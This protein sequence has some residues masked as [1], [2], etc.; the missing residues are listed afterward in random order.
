MIYKFDEKTLTFKSVTSNVVVILLSIILVITSIIGYVMINK[1]NQIKYITQETKIAIIRENNEFSEEKLIEYMKEIHMRFPHIVLAQA[2]IETGFYS[3]LVF[4]Q[5]NN[6]FGM[7]LAKQRVRYSI[8]EKLNHATYTTWR[9]S[10]DDY[11]IRQAIEYSGIH[12]ES[13]YYECLKQY[14][15]D[16]TYS[17]KVKEMA[18]KCKILFED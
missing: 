18:D 1:V 10:V 12:R 16:P 3:S 8:G 14:A 5:N 11:A 7:K 15:E 13:D 17:A 4:K 6:V 9:R 2:R